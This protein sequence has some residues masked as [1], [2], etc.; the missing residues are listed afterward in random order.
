MAKGVLNSDGCFFVGTMLATWLYGCSL[1]QTMYY[2]KTYS[3]DRI[4][5][6]ILMTW[7]WLIIGHANPVVVLVLPSFFISNI[8]RRSLVYNISSK[9]LVSGGNLN[10]DFITN[11][12]NCLESI[13]QLLSFI[14]LGKNNSMPLIADTIHVMAPLPVLNVR[15][16][17]VDSVADAFTPMSDPVSI[18]S[19]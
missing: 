12:N 17:I 3:K 5:L 4:Y 9:G 1:A 8:W 15:H 10:F 6:K 11:R 16:H 13:V 19:L 7:V 14:N 2:M 18:S